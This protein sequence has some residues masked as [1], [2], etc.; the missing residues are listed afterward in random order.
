[1]DKERMHELSKDIAFLVNYEA[2][3]GE[4]STQD[5]ELLN[6]KLQELLKEQ[7]ELINDNTE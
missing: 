7:E 4:L 5:R 1:M 6:D 3:Y 2:V